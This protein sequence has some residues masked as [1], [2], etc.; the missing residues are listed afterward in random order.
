MV[1]SYLPINVIGFANHG[2][3]DSL[4]AMRT[5]MNN[6]GIIVFPG[7]ELST[8]EKAHFVCLFSEETTKV[9]LDHYFGNLGLT[10]P[11]NGIWPSNLSGIDIFKKVEELGGFVYAAH[12]TDDSGVLNRKIAQVWQNS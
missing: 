11:E 7:F 6:Q 2:N 12:C 9:Q 5:T 10:N 4:D 8:A 1:H 3:V